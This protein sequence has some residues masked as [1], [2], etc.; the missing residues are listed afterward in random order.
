M[1]IFMRIL[2]AFLPDSKRPSIAANDQVR[3]QIAILKDEAERTIDMID[4]HTGIWHQDMLEGT[5]QGLGK[6]RDTNRA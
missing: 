3:E 2:S 4:Q 6:P 5:Y 1:N